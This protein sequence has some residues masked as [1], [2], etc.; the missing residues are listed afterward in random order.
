MYHKKCYVNIKLTIPSATQLFISIFKM[1]RK[2]SKHL[3]CI[4]DKN[5]YKWYFLFFSNKCTVFNK[6]DS[7]KKSE[8]IYGR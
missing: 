8:K 2:T 3:C 4:K 1:K 5:C 6:D 7:R